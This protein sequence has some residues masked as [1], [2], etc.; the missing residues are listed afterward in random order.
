MEYNEALL[1]LE[2]F[3]NYERSHEAA[4]MRKVRL[5]RMQRLCRLA[6]NPQQ[7]FRSVVVTGTNG[8][9]S[10][11]AMLYAML[12]AS[13]LKAGLYTSPHLEDVRERI[14]FSSGESD[15]P[16]P[17]EGKDWISK[18]AFAEAVTLLKPAVETLCQESRE[19][20]PTYFEI[21][22]AVAFVAFAQQKVKI[23]VLE[24]GMGGRLDATNIVRQSVSV[25]GPID[26]DHTDVLGES[27][28]AIAREKAGILKMHQIAVSVVQPPEVEAVLQQACDA[29]GVPLL[30]LG[31]DISVR[32]AEQTLEGMQITVAGLRGIYESVKLPMLGRH[33]ASNA[34]VAIVALEALSSK[35]IPRTFI[36]R[37]LSRFS[38]PGRQEIFP[39]SPLIV[40]DGGHNP[41]AMAALRASLE[42]ACP[43]RTVHFLMGVSGDKSVEEIGRRLEGFAASITCTQ[44]A[45]PRAMP[46]GELAKRIAPYC[47]E[48]QIM[49]DPVD[50]ATYLLNI[51]APEDVVVV[52]GSFFLVGQLRAALKQSHVKSPRVA[53]RQEVAA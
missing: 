42:Q 6:G 20:P 31:R 37:G 53:K 47:K 9:G 48:V 4:A 26:L 41:H 14:R 35:G 32:V 27:P 15:R 52:S 25:F 46:A 18:E 50:A 29:H 10:I 49:P 2:Q 7:R 43:G 5:S 38:W 24:V 11:A 12:R 51:A 17:A 1:Y 19:G 21:L 33:Q 30:L 16:L 36:E 23:A 22:T 45:H 8:K 40:F 44:S 28:A 34:A 39:H 13:K 3:V